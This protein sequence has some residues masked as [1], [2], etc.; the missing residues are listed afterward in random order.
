MDTAIMDCGFNYGYNSEVMFPVTNVLEAT[1]NQIT[2]HKV[3][4]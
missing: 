2:Y 1:M 4:Q 3:C